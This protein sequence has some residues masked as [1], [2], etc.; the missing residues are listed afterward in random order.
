MTRSLRLT[1]RPLS[2]VEAPDNMS[3]NFHELPTTVK[4]NNQILKE[5]VQGAVQLGRDQMS[6]L[7]RLEDNLNKLGSTM[8]H[9]D[10]KLNNLDNRLKDLQTQVNQQ[11][12]EIESIAHTVDKMQGEIK[13]MTENVTC[14]LVALTT[15]GDATGLI[16]PALEHLQGIKNELGAVMDNGFLEVQNK[17]DGI[18]RTIKTGQYVLLTTMTDASVLAE[19]C[20]RGVRNG[21]EQLLEEVKSLANVA[22]VI[23]QTAENVSDMKIHVGDGVNEIILN[24]ENSARLQM[25]DFNTTM[26]K[27]FDDVALTILES[28]NGGLINLSTNIKQELSQFMKQIGNTSLHQGTSRDLQEQTYIIESRSEQIIGL[29]GKLEENFN[30]QQEWLLEKIPTICKNNSDP[31]ENDRTDTNMDIDSSFIRMPSE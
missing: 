18:E 31:N 28:Q 15:T 12:S 21:Y 13:E 19:G 27:M 24:I 29:I 25:K 8:M 5:H 22:Q 7:S 30:K 17:L 2:P 26:N 16:S 4:E 10:A 1:V 14:I 3:P 6:S 20:H 11:S 23:N 9:I